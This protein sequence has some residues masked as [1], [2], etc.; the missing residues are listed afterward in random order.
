[1]PRA[2]ATV[3]VDVLVVATPA[4]AAAALLA[5]PF[6]AAAAELAR[7]R[8]LSSVT[9]SLAYPRTAVAHALDATGFVVA[10]E[11]QVEGFR[12]CSFV[13]SK[14][15]GRAPGGHALLR[16]FFRP[17]DEELRDL[18]DE[19]WVARAERSARRALTIQ[20]APERSWVSRWPH[21]LPV[22]DAVHRAR[23]AELEQRLAG[24]GVL[25]AGACFHGAGIDGAVR[26]AAAA[27]RAL[28]A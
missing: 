14:L 21:A 11:A 8:A 25:L 6:G 15:R 17:S 1:V 16:L 26:S 2:G 22:F 23:V 7:S 20:G 9:V 27:A 13:S 4:A 5:E 19:A 3:E 12:A 28:D 24:S 18:G 10:E